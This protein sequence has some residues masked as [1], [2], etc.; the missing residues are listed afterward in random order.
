MV[1]FHGADENCGQGFA[2]KVG[3]ARRCRRPLRVQE[4]ADFIGGDLRE[5]GA[6][7]VAFSASLNSFANAS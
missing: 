6:D 5:Q 1:I 3:R 4:A 2:G 7:G